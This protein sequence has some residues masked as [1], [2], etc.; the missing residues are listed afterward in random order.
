MA[1]HF[2][3]WLRLVLTTWEAASTSGAHGSSEVK[4]PQPEVQLSAASYPAMREA[5]AASAASRAP[6]VY[7]CSECITVANEILGGDTTVPA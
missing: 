5:R 4:R 7:I 1:P 2:N 3:S 6:G